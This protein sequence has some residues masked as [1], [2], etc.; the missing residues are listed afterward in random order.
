MTLANMLMAE[1]QMP[2]VLTM[3][4]IFVGSFI[5]VT[6]GSCLFDKKRRR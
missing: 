1:S 4:S 3:I 6:I 2:T 5:G